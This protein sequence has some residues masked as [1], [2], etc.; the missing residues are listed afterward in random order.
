MNLQSFYGWGYSKNTTESN[1]NDMGETRLSL[2]GVQIY[3]EL[4]LLLQTSKAPTLVPENTVILTSPQHWQLSLVG[5]KTW[6]LESSRPGTITWL[7]HLPAV[8]LWQ[9]HLCALQFLHLQ[10]TN[11]INSYLVKLL[12]RKNEV[13]TRKWFV[14]CLVVLSLQASYYHHW[15]FKSCTDDPVR[16]LP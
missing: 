3:S 5:L 7:C 13:M 14:W 1:K 9:R 10:Y 16:V 6:V 12:S 15:F 4:K 8:W 2:W 11:N